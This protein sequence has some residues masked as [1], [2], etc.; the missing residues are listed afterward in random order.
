MIQGGPVNPLEILKR[1]LAHQ[2]FRDVNVAVGYGG[3]AAKKE[4]LLKAMIL[5]GHD[6]CVQL[7]WNHPNIDVNLIDGIWDD[8]PLMVASTVGR[9]EMVKLL[10]QHKDIDI[11]KESYQRVTALVYASRIGNIEIVKLL[12]QH[13]NIDINKKNFWTGKT[14]LQMA[15]EKGHENVVHLLR[16]H[17]AIDHDV[18]TTPPGSPGVDNANSHAVPEPHLEE[19]SDHELESQPYSFLDEY[20]EDLDGSEAMD[21]RPTTWMNTVLGKNVDG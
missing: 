4:T 18:T 3:F 19:V 5:H 12:L 2:D 7:L 20:M 11:N 13:A 15:E 10:L 6:D 1:L 21:E 9:I 8:T 16:E 17:G 14:V